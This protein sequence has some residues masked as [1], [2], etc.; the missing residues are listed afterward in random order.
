MVEFLP[1]VPQYDLSLKV[2]LDIFMCPEMSQP[3]SSAAPSL[4]ASVILCRLFRKMHAWRLIFPPHR[5]TTIIKLSRRAWR[6]ILFFTF[7]IINISGRTLFVTV[8]CSFCY[9]T[10]AFSE[11]INVGYPLDRL[12]DC[13]IRTVATIQNSLSKKFLAANFI[14]LGKVE[15]NPESYPRTYKEPIQ[16]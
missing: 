4:I 6:T 16:T 10:I 11:R 7:R 14:R 1:V 9:K 12:K 8:R 2:K 15:R 3:S 5:A 13:E